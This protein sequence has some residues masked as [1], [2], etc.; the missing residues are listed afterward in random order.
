MADVPFSYGYQDQRRDLSVVLTTVQQMRPVWL[1]LVGTGQRSKNHKT[2]WTEEAISPEQ[3]TLSSACTTTA[4]KIVVASKLPFAVNAIIRFEGYGELMR[5]TSI[6][7]VADEVNVSR[8]YGGTTKETASIALGAKVFIVSKPQYES[9][10]PT[11]ADRTVLPGKNYNYTEI[12]SE[13]AVISNSA[14][15]IETLSGSEDDPVGV[16]MN[17]QVDLKMK[18][19]AYRKNN[20][21][22]YGRRFERTDAI[23]GTMG[24]LLQF[25]E[26]G[27]IIPGAGAAI[28]QK[29]LDD[30]FASC[31]SGGA[32]TLN[33][34]L[35]GAVQARNISNLYAGKLTI[36]REDTVQGR[37]VY[38]VQGSLPIN[39]YITKV[40]VDPAF[41]ADKISLFDS[42]NIRERPNRPLFDESSRSGGD[43]FQARR[44]LEETTFE[45]NNWQ[46][47]TAL[48]QGLSTAIAA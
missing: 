32:T 25:H 33:T 17:R 6:S 12:I 15:G 18:Q 28:S 44:L 4:T 27:N 42:A 38:T 23:P 2:E 45:F 30:A 11:L 41:P 24:G 10:R 31:F 14:P 13:E 47:T 5:V 26:G 29:L 20:A 3:T 43:D 8:A 34:L 19:I 16:L 48:I 21:L 37:A 46:K 40:V 9:S 39:G 35:C 1:S 36:A 22:I 7:D